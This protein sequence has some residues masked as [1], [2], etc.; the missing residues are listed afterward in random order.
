MKIC[1]PPISNGPLNGVKN[2][3]C[4][5]G[6]IARLVYIGLHEGE[7]IAA[8]TSKMIAGAQDVGQASG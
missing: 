5:T 6:A 3:L 8:E 7:L 1:W 4:E 2:T